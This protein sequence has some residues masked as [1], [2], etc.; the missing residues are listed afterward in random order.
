M[1][2]VAWVSRRLRKI[3][4]PTVV[5]YIWLVLAYLI[6]RPSLPSLSG[7]EGTTSTIYEA[8]Q[9]MGKYL[10]FVAATLIAF[11]LGSATIGLLMP[12][13]GPLRVPAD[14]R[15]VHLRRP[16]LTG[17]RLPSYGNFREELTTP[18]V[19]HAVVPP[20]LYS[21]G[22]FVD[23]FRGMCLQVQV[24]WAAPVPLLVLEVY[25][26]AAHSRWWLIA[27]AITPVFLYLGYR[28]YVL[29]C[30]M[31]NRAGLAHAE[32]MHGE[33]ERRWFEGPERRTDPPESPA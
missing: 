31:L 8:A 13:L 29:A 25:L 30:R 32:Q 15:Q 18:Y 10:G 16:E 33:A 14:V 19:L 3:A 22:Q 1:A 26:T 12:L 4:A 5:G 11:A 21:L 6:V 17:R 28:R 23:D 9:T 20:E 2:R 7:A 27:V 24:F